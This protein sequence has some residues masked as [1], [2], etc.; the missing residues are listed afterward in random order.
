MDAVIEYLSQNVD[1]ILQNHAHILYVLAGLALV[2]ELT[3]IGLSGP[4]L[5]F[6][7]GCCITALFIDLGIVSSWEL[8]VLSVGILSILSAVI[9]WKPLQ[10][11]QG[12][13][14]VTDNSSDMIGK[15]VSVSNE[16]TAGGGSIRYSG[17]DWQAKLDMDSALDA[18]VEGMQVE[19][20]AVDG[21]TMIV[22]EQ[23]T[24]SA[25]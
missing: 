21:T 17:I 10:K 12:A 11:F 18:F 9:L 24:S 6:A 15:V 7:L 3:V 25:D 13:D 8:E 4:L 14:N 1:Y 2:L 22:K 20:C 5:F 23:D 16:V 19:I